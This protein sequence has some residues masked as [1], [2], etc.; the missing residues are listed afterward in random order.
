MRKIFDRSIFTGE[1]GA[2]TML[3]E[4]HG[5]IVERQSRHIHKSAWEA[6][7][8]QPA[9]QARHDAWHEYKRQV[10]EDGLGRELT[11]EIFDKLRARLSDRAAA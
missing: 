2:Y 5:A 10:D 11:L 4:Q 8:T 9:Q 7:L 3:C 1:I 6:W